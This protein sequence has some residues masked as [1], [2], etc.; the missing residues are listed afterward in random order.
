MNDIKPSMPELVVSYDCTTYDFDVIVPFIQQSY[1]GAGR[2]RD[3]IVRAFQHSWTVGLFLPGGQQIGWARATS[4]TVF[5][6]Y[7]FDLAVIERFRGR[8][9]GRRLV[10]VLMQH[11]ELTNVTGWMLSTRY[12]HDLY[13]T[14]GFEDAEQGRYMTLKKLQ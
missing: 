11:P 7:I 3:D 2:R 14:F 1:W 4:D 5:H 9:I 13:R 12:H 6:A 10:E 8:G